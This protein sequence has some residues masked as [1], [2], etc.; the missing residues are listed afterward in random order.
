MAS[1][2]TANGVNVPVAQHLV[3]VRGPSNDAT[4][5][6]Q[7][8]SQGR[9]AAAEVHQAKAHHSCT[10]SRTQIISSPLQPNQAELRIREVLI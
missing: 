5:A 6:S 3:R 2:Q 9:R 7:E 10:S 1:C 4:D 8:H